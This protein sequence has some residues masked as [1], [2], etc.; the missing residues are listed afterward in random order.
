MQRHGIGPQIQR[1]SS[2]STPHD[3]VTVLQICS[4]RSSALDRPRQSATRYLPAAAN[5][6]TIHGV[7]HQP[8]L[9]GLP[10]N[11][12]T[13]RCI[14]SIPISQLA[15][16]THIPIAPAAPPYVPS[17][18]V[19]SPGGFRTPAAELAAPSLKRPRREWWVA[20]E[21]FCHVTRL[22]L[23][24]WLPLCS[25]ALSGQAPKPLAARRRRGA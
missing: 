19:S 6:P 8:S 5:R 25:A 23:R 24:Q 11:R 22:H 2:R 21:S 9:I 10:L 15:R 20:V 16:G 12:R 1:A 17:S 13:T 3:R 18:A 4:L 14:G 7:R